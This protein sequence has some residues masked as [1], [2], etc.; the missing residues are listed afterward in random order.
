MLRNTLTVVTQLA[1]LN[2]KKGV[3]IPLKMLTIIL[4]LCQQ[5]GLLTAN[6]SNQKYIKGTRKWAFTIVDLTWFGH[7]VLDEHRSK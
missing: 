5:A 4:K 7:E 1:S 2:L 3:A 6:E